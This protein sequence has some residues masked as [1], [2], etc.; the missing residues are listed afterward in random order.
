MQFR[1]GLAGLLLNPFYFSRAS[2]Y[3][4][5]ERTLAS[6]K[7]DLLDVGCG[8]SPY[9]SLMPNVHYVGVDIDTP[10]SRK[11]SEADFFYDGAVL[12]FEPASFDHILCSQVLEHVFT[13]DDF[14][15]EMHRVL[16]P[17]GT[18]A[19]A[20]PFVWDEHEQPYDF[21]RYSSFG[22]KALLVR[23]GFEV[24]EQRKTLADFRAVVQLTSL[25]IYKSTRTR[26]RMVNL[27]IQLIVIAPLNAGGWIVSLLL[28]SNADF[29]IDNVVL[30][31]KTLS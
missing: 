7:G 24:M 19:L 20:V 29:Y 26:S 1:P 8:R 4:A 27:F 28:P 13:A 15:K 16:R 10:A 21:G 25:W 5:L 22:L 6:L 14:L 31:K 12:P 11:Y 17:G 30:A 18:L 3:D 9:R 2:L 23:N